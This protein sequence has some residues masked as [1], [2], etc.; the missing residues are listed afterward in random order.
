[1]GQNL[2]E[3]LLADY[4]LAMRE[5][6]NLQQLLSEYEHVLF[7]GGE[8]DSGFT[9]NDYDLQI[10]SLKKKTNGHILQNVAHMSM[11][12]A[13]EELLEISLG[14]LKSI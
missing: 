10:S 12:E 1:M 14:F 7:I 3:S 2:D 6:P 8:K 5:R 9:A 11:Y 13:P 4:M